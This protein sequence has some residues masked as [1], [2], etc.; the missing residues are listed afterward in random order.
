MYNLPIKKIRAFKIITFVMIVLALISS[1]VVSI[2]VTYIRTYVNGNSMYPTLNSSFEQT[3]KCDVVYINRFATSQ[4][5]DIVVLDL[6]NH[7][8]F[9]NYAI[10]RLIATEG[11]VV[12][13][14][15]D[16]VNMK[17][18]LIVNGK[19]ITSKPYQQGFNTY[20]NLQ[21]YITNHEQDNSRII[22][23]ESDEL[24]GVM[25]KKNEI[26][27]LGDNWETSKDS[28]LVGPFNISTIV[29]RVDIV[30]KPD[31]NEFLCVLKRIF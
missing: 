18:D 31:E 6:R 25:V 16:A 26:F 17:Y 13:I 5:G 15:L 1:S 10:K 7:S 30:V 19:C 3:G 12:N 11:S 28:A 4:V 29:G 20:N 9:G 8:S 2:N 21:Q 27:A 24:A 23:D 22:K 14:T